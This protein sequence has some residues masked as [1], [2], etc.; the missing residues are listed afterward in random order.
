MM[1]EERSYR[2]IWKIVF[3]AVVFLDVQMVFVEGEERSTDSTGAKKTTCCACGTATYRLKFMG[4]WTRTRHPK[5]HPGR[6]AYFS[7]LIGASHANDFVLWRIGHY[8]SS[9]IRKMSEYGS[10]ADLVQEIA[11]NGARIRSKIQTKPVD[12]CC[13]SA[14]ASFKVDKYRHLFSAMSRVSPSPDWNVGVDSLDLCDHSKCVWKKKI[15]VNLEPWDAGTDSGI[16]F[17]SPNRETIPQE[18]I[19]YITKRRNLHAGSSLHM[20]ANKVPA[21]AKVIL[22]LARTEGQCS[23]DSTAVPKVGRAPGTCHVSGWTAWTPCST[24][25]GMGTRNRGRVI[26][27][28]G[29]PQLCPQL[30]ETSNCNLGR[31]GK[32]G[33]R[34]RPIDCQVSKWTS[35][36][37]CSVTCGMGKIV[38]TRNVLQ[39]PARGGKPCRRLTRIKTCVKDPC[40]GSK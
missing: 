7:S 35:W 14:R 24:T 1:A 26:L 23:Q 39:F 33:P 5:H 32:G 38:K 34:R 28:S 40:P 13:G 17:V 2:F 25:C 15:E 12:S 37:S 16:T 10:H 36:T 4:K 21:L 29:S 20:G 22:H 18:L 19:H 3:L 8:A 11:L 31:C 6:L 30:K 27:N 9:G